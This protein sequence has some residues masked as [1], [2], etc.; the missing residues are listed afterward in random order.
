MD[1]AT[2]NR[3]IQAISE[4]LSFDILTLDPE[5]DIEEQVSLD[6]M[7][8]VGVASKIERLLD[9]ELPLSVMESRTLNDFFAIIDKELQA[10]G[11]G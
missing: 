3:L 6:S 7:Q 4:E 1:A 5:R 8:L 11:A 9:I 2:R 10:G